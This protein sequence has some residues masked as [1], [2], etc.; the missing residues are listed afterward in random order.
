M[1]NG[2]LLGDG[3][4]SPGSGTR[5]D[6]KLPVVFVSLELVSVTRN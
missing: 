6:E 1:L 4:V 5:V 2:N 3:I